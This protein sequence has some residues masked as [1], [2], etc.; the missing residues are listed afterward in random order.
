MGTPDPSFTTTR[1]L[2]LT[3][4]QREEEPAKGL[5]AKR[6]W[7]P[8]SGEEKLLLRS[9]SAGGLCCW[10]VRWGLGLT[11]GVECGALRGW[12]EAEGGRF[13]EESDTAGLSVSFWQL[14]NY[15]ELK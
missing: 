7:N 5:R 14:A 11:L 15:R 1:G 4:L 13:R 6:V 9:G 8:G 10:Q 12:D 2:T 3:T